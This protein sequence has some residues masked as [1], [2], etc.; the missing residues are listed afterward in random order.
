MEGMM[1]PVDVLVQHA[2][3]DEDVEVSEDLPEREHRLG[4]GD[5]V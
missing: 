5:L 4:L 2:A 1:T 3:G